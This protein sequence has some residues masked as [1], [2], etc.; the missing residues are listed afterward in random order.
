[1]NT[2]ISIS[3]TH[4][5]S[6]LNNSNITKINSIQ[7]AKEDSL[8]P[9]E[10]Y[11][12]YWQKL[13][14]KIVDVHK[15]KAS[16]DELRSV[17]EEV[18]EDKQRNYNIAIDGYCKFWRKK[19]TAIW[20]KPINGK[21]HKGHLNVSINPEICLEH[22]GKLYLIKLFLHIN[23]KLDRKQA[24]M[25]TWIMRD[26]LGEKVPNNMVL[27]VLD[28]KNGRLYEERETNNNIKLYVEVEADSFCKYW[29]RL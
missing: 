21:W 8:E 12:D 1:M 19:K 20:N 9:Y 11:K 4:F 7:K 22:K 3:L 26:G 2:T 10:A 13:K 29:N 23:E 24:D 15:L 5:M 28:V 25:I 14:Q 16:E 27:C 17:V 6:F 18:S